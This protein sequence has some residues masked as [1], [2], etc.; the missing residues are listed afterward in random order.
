[1]KVS[2]VWGN[3]THNSNRAVGFPLY[4]LIALFILPPSALQLI[5]QKVPESVATE[6]PRWYHIVF[7]LLEIM[8]SV[9]IIT[10]LGMGDTPD[11]ARL[12]RI[13]VIVLGGVGIIYFIVAWVYQA[14]YPPL[15][16][17]AW[18][19]LAFSVFCFIRWGQI[20]RKIARM[21]TQVDKEIASGEV[22]E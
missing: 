13:A 19:Q 20:N 17:A 16:Q 14:P 12:E 8:G 15:T 1:M 18:M 3:L 21:M 2:A 11:S 6:T 7:I 22:V 10:A 5:L 9:F 4:R